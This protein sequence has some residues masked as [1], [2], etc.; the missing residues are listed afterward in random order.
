MG[1]SIHEGKEELQKSGNGCDSQS[2]LEEM[3]TVARKCLE[4]THNKVSF[5]VQ[6]INVGRKEFSIGWTFLD[7]YI[8]TQN[9]PDNITFHFKVST[10][11]QLK[12]VAIKHLLPN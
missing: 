10:V 2:V 4:Y 3:V 6:N 1:V 7:I 5:L 9:L 11:N 8:I 12:S